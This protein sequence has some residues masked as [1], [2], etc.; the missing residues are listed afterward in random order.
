[1]KAQELYDQKKREAREAGY[2]LNPDQDLVLTLMEGLL[3]NQKRYG[4]QS[5]PCRLS[6]GVR[7]KD[8]DII[9]PCD[10]RDQDLAEYGACYCGLYVDSDT[11]SGKKE[12][13]SIPERRGTVSKGSNGKAGFKVSFPVYRCRVCGYLCAKENPPRVCP[14][15][16]ATSDRFEIFLSV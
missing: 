2:I 3:D 7:E 15:C 12:L 11:A 9:C 4:Y 10:Y 13:T 14:I 6:E 16:K 5:C 8:R 1:M